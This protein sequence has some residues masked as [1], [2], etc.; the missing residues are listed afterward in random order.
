MENITSVAL[1]RLVAQSR[2]LEVTATNLANANTP[3]FRAERTVFSDWMA[4]EPTRGLPKGGRDLA[5]AQDVETYRD[6]TV[7]TRTHT[8]NPL[9]IAIGNPGGWLTVLTPKGPRLT[10]AGHFELGT[11]GTIIDEN[12]NALLDVAGNKLQTAPTDTELTIAADGSLSGA[13]GQIGQIG[14]VQ[15]TDSTKM[16]AEGGHLLAAGSP[17]A[18]VAAPQ[19]IQG[20]L[21]DSNVQPIGELTRMMN[22][23]REFQMTTQ[24]IQAEIDRQNGA[25]DKIMAKRS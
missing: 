20:A 13:D 25:I 1:S 3:G 7:G 2:G 18:A 16:Q 12:G 4:R 21:E 8:A 19:I 22:D 23:M 5:Y 6:T 9:D 24:M 10:R 15:P 11:D 17:T 14:V